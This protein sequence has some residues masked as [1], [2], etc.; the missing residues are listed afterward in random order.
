MHFV[1]IEGR[2]VQIVTTLQGGLPQTPNLQSR[3][4]K[5]K[6]RHYG[7]ASVYCTVTAL[8]FIPNWFSNLSHLKPINP[9]ATDFATR[10]CPCDGYINTEPIC[11]ASASQQ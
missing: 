7:I 10:A 11:A 5:A 6:H 3:T 9:W 2:G 4:M 8:S 1:P